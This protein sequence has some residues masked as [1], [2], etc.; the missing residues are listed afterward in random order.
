M[1]DGSASVNYWRVV[2]DTQGPENWL[3]GSEERLGRLAQVVGELEFFSIALERLG[4][5]LRE[6][7]SGRDLNL[8][9]VTADSSRPHS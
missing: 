4:I 9:G 7:L 1:C 3:Q 5:Q 2:G 8:D 6:G